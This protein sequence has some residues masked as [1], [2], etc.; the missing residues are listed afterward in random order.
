VTIS[1]ILL[2][3][4]G[5]GP[6]PIELGIISLIVSLVAL[7]LIVL[8]LV[9]L[10]N[11]MFKFLKRWYILAIH[12]RYSFEYLTFFKENDLRSPVISCIKDEI[13][14]HLM[15]FFR[16]LKN[17]VD[18][19][20]TKP[21]EFDKVPF[22]IPSQDLLKIKGSPDC[23]KVEKQG[24][25]RFLVMGYHETLQ[26]MKM[27]SMYFFVNDRF[28]M[29]EYLFPDISHLNPAGL[30]RTFSV[31]Y[32]DDHPVENDVFYIT[33]TSGNQLNFEN[34]G[35]TISIKY[36]FMGDTGMNTLMSGLFETGNQIPGKNIH[37]ADYEEALAR[38]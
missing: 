22:M 14:M 10:K 31:K 3:K 5:K 30:A 26:G 20:T 38:F 6:S 24:Q 29:G 13:A 12:G 7:F 25:N 17:S 19:L 27:R 33:D 37:K 28:I 16:K 18:F 1:A 21:I 34:N 32:L 23:M 35:F 2:I 15:V 11:R 4:E 36:L 8:A 9:L